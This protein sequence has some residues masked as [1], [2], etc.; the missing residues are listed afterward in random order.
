MNL[1]WLYLI[2]RILKRYLSK[3]SELADDRS[4]EDE[5]EEV[6]EDGEKKVNGETPKVLL[7]GSPVVEDGAKKVR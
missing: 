3:D 1:F 5:E 7:N 4:D 6:E 2:F